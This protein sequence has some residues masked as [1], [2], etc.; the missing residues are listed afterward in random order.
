MGFVVLKRF[1]WFAGWFLGAYFLGGYEDDGKGVNGLTKAVFAAVKSWAVG[2]SLGVTI[3]A[4]TSSHIPPA[5]FVLVTMGSTGILLIGWRA[6][7][8]TLL[9]YDQRKK[10]DV[11]RRGSPFEL[12]EL[13]TSLVRRW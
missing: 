5:S 9:P 11:Y 7:I 13:L 10:N 1:E 8:S 12:F 6:L 3:R 4:A 2:I